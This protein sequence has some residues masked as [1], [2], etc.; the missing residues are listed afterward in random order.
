LADLISL[1][2]VILDGYQ[3]LIAKKPAVASL[4]NVIDVAALTVHTLRVSQTAISAFEVALIAAAP[5]CRFVFSLWFSEFWYFIRKA[6]FKNKFQPF[7]DEIDA[8]LAAAIQA[9]S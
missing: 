2:P 8:A 1:K 9:Y 4:L 3:T 5:V 7:I 6:D